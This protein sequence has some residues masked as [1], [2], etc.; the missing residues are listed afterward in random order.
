MESED[1]FESVRE[2][3]VEVLLLRDPAKVTQASSLIGDLGA[4]S[5]DI[6]DMIFHL[7]ERFGIKISK[8]EIN[9]Y[10]NLGLDESETHLEGVLTPKAVLKLRE[11]MPEADPVAIH[12][13]MKVADVPR[14][15]TVAALVAL[16]KRKL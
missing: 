5:L 14:L 4:D 3:L 16:V 7:E 8:A 6:L 1:I 2:I 12:D 11:M 13:G 9:Y 10:Q 15:I